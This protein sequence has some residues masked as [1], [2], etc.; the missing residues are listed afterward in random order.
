M[1]VTHAPTA[2]LVRTEKTRSLVSARRDTPELP[3]RQVSVFL[4]Q[5][6]SPMPISSAP[7]TMFISWYDTYAKISII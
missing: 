5:L 7:S 2:E 4:L 6:L 3:A 1:K